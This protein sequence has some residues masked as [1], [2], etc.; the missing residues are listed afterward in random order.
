MIALKVYLTAAT[1]I[2]MLAFLVTY[3]AVKETWSIRLIGCTFAGFVVALPIGLV[4]L[5]WTF[6]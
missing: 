4:A 1:V 6:F 3:I 5:I 2:S